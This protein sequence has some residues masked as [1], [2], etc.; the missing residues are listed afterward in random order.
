MKK[1]IATELCDKEKL[2]DAYL[3]VGESYQKV[4]EFQKARKWFTKS[5]EIYKV[6][7]NLEVSIFF[8]K[9]SWFSCS[10]FA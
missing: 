8:L 10:S 6:I 3:V 5:W 1:K 2:A 9:T 7:G 4:R